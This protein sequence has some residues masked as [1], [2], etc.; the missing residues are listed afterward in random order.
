MQRLAG[1]QTKQ[2]KS[3]EEAWSSLQAAFDEQLALSKPGNFEFSALMVHYIANFDY[4]SPVWLEANFDSL[5]DKEYPDN[6]RA[7]LA[8]LPYATLTRRVYRLLADRGM[9]AFSDR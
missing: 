6:F 2:K 8:G 4:L 5:L 9:I 3:H 7:T 1:L